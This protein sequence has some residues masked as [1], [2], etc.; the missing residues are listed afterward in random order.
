MPPPIP[1]QP[2]RSQSSSSI[3]QRPSSS[4]NSAARP[5]KKSELLCRVKWNNTLPDLPFDPKFIMYPF[6]PDRFKKYKPTSLEKEYKHDLLTEHDLGVNID[7]ISPETYGVPSSSLLPPP[8]APEDERLIEEDTGLSSDGANKSS[9]FNE[10]RSKQHNLVVPWLKKTEYISTEFNRYGASSE[11]NETKVGYYVQKKFKDD[12]EKMIC[13]DKQGQIAAINKTFEEA[14]KPIKQHHSKKSV[15][16]VEEFPLFPDFDHWKLPFAQVSFDAEPIN[17][18]NTD[19]SLVNNKL[20]SEAIIRAGLDNTTGENYVAYFLPTQET[21]IKRSEDSSVG[22]DYDPEQEYIYQQAR[23]YTCSIKNKMSR[24]YDGNYFFVKRDDA[25][26]YNELETKV[27]LTKRRTKAASASAKLIVRHR[28]FNESD[29]KTHTT[30]LNALKPQIE[31]KNDDEEEED[32]EKD[33]SQARES[34]D[35]SGK[36]DKAK[37][38]SSED[39]KSP[40]KETQTAKRDKRKHSAESKSASDDGSSSS[41]AS[42]SSGSSSSSDSESASSPDRKKQKT[43]S[44]P[45]SREVYS[46]DS[47]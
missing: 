45:S 39:E 13:M 8:L 14:K 22:I 1:T 36:N 11:N 26:Y 25:F 21:L 15:Y 35:E 20:M 44:K 19:Q 42:A 47:D 33:T 40:V 7:L 41:S 2:H 24:G 34:G 43:K 12:K 32:K 5:V 30:R 38:S 23:E 16:A 6:D 28:P 46:S 27:K 31:D 18:D 37:S 4:S 9:S 29:L 17:S 3:G 10:K